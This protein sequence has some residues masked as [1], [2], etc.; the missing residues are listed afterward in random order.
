ML[1][2]RMELNELNTQILILEICQNFVKL[3]KN[4]RIYFVNYLQ[5]TYAGIDDVYAELVDTITMGLFEFETMLRDPSLNASTAQN[6]EEDDEVSLRRTH[7]DRL[8][9]HQTNMFIEDFNERL[10][11]VLALQEGEVQDSQRNLE[12]L[13]QNISDYLAEEVEYNRDYRGI[14]SLSD[15][16]DVESCELSNTKSTY[17]TEQDSDD[18]DNDADTR[19]NVDE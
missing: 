18:D 11:I 19:M 4:E 10:M 15:L 1:L 17:D 3:P 13:L 6:C 16:S 8:F 9:V 7:Q 2:N 12:V 5:D 14:E